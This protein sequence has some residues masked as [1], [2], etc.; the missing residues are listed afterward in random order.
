MS[1]V[2]LIIAIVFFV[3]AALGTA[4]GPLA[5]IELVYLGLACFAAAHLPLP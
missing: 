2:L 3:V 5:P 4:I 1:V